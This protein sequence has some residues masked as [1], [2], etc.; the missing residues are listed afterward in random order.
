MFFLQEL[1]KI[2]AL[3]F[4]NISE[5]LD[6]ADKLYIFS[7]FAIRRCAPRKT[8]NIGTNIKYAS[9]DTPKSNKIH[10]RK[11]DEFCRRCWLDFGL[12][13]DPQMT[14]KSSKIAPLGTQVA[15]WGSLGEPWGPP[16][17]PR[18]PIC[19]SN[20]AP[21][22]T[23]KRPQN[24]SKWLPWAPKG[25]LGAPWGNHAPTPICGSNLAPQM[26]LK[27]PQNQPKWH[28]WDLR[29]PLGRAMPNV[30][31][32]TRLR[33][34]DTP[35]PQKT[36]EHASRPLL[37]QYFPKILRQPPKYQTLPQIFEHQF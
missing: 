5:F 35:P 21:Q 23:L 20:L 30:A 2:L 14:P 26:I 36:N 16:D 22:M 31:K 6:T 33:K 10:Y 7:C 8:S 1:S 4:L 34:R 11:N 25:P 3:G 15:P 19:G 18:R 24:Q 27:R 37:T 28:P 17:A 12:K 32:I 13:T 9:R 29:K